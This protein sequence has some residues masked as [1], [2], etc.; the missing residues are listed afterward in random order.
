[1]NYYTIIASFND[2]ETPGMFMDTFVGVTPENAAQYC[3]ASLGN[4]AEYVEDM[5]AVAGK[6]DDCLDIDAVMRG[7]RVAS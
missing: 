5:I 4:R 3:L 6:H 7:E 1:M 2:G